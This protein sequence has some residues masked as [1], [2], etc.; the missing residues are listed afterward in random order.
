MNLN[1]YIVMKTEV[2]V[3]FFL[4]IFIL[5]LVLL[6]NE[7]SFC[8]IPI[9]HRVYPA[10]LCSDC[11]TIPSRYDKYYYTQWYDELP[12]Y[13]A[14]DSCYTDSFYADYMDLTLAVW[15]YAKQPMQVKGLVALVDP[16]SCGQPYLEDVK[17]PEYTRLYQ[18][19]MKDSSWN[20]MPTPWAMN[21]D[22]QLLD[23][24]RWDTVKPH[25]MPIEQGGIH[26]IVKYIYAYECYFDTPIW[27]DSDFYIDG[28][29]N[30]NVPY[31]DTIWGMTYE[32]VAY[33]IPTWYVAIGRTNVP[34]KGFWDEECPSWRTEDPI[35]SVMDGHVAVYDQV[36]NYGWHCPWPVSYIGMFLPIVD[37]LNIEVGVCDTARGSV[38]GGG[39]YPVGWYDTLVAVP[40]YGYAFDGWNDGCT[41]NPRIVHPNGDTSFSACFVSTSCHDIQVLSDNE[42]WGSVSGGGCYYEQQ[43]ATI[44]ATP[45]P[46]HLFSHWND[47]NTDNPRIVYA[48]S[49]T[50]FTAHFIEPLYMLTVTSDNED[51][52]TVDGS[53]IYYHGDTAVIS[54]TPIGYTLFDSW[55]DGDWSNPRSVVVSQD[56]SFK[57]FF[58]SLDGIESPYVLHFSIAPNP[59]TNSIGVVVGSDMEN[60]HYEVDIFDDKGSKVLSTTIEGPNSEVDISSIS[61]GIYYLRVSANGKMG[62]KSF[63]K[64]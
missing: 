1:K 46:R 55:N 38:R 33:T 42:A 51:L 63:V 62:V 41:D 5:S 59:A 60:G 3:G 40:N 31:H 50:L 47:G 54:A 11:D 32:H 37:Q 4:K 6:S 8:Q 29:Y 14:T 45:T 57:A 53:G 18:L 26:N 22:L 48:S 23:S 35:W 12:L 16:T 64:K 13:G 9:T 7:A 17:L 49:D 30:N 44:E 36:G 24:L 34:K 43:P 25:W 19:T 61:S 39:R 15:H 21:I 10:L 28:T 52:G 2:K 20:G 58:M 56:T 27:V